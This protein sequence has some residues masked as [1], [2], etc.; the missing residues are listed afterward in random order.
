MR[1][2]IINDDLLGHTISIDECDNLEQARELFKFHC[3][4]PAHIYDYFLTL[5][6]WDEKDEYVAE[7]DEYFFT[8]LDLD[9]SE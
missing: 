2:K 6:E 3:Y 5:E 1:Y 8:R 7:L 9:E 4:T